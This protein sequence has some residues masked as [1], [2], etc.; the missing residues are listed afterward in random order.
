MLDSHLAYPILPLFR[1]SHDGQSWVSALGAV[2]D[3]ATI[4]ITVVNESRT[5]LPHIRK[6]RVAAAMMYSIGCHAL[7]DLTQ[8]PTVR[9]H[10]VRGNRDPG[11]ERSEFDVACQRLGQFGFCAIC[12]DE[13]WKEFAEHRAVYSQRLNLL[14]RYL[15]TPP[16]QWIGDRSV[17]TNHELDHFGP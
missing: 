11:I 5:S 8:S 13:T 9:R 10:V 2:L 14:A 4:L 7:A 1:S 16:T 3:A 6:C 15:A 12:S 17:V